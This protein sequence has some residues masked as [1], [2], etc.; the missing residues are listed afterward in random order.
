MTDHGSAVHPANGVRLVCQRE[1]WGKP[2]S[3][4]IADAIS[5]RPNLPKFSGE[6][7]RMARSGVFDGRAS[8]SPKR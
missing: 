6:N 7:R 3:A 8:G 4:I 2:K 5:Q 1:K